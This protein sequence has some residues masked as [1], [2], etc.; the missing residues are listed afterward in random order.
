MT[1]FSERPLAIIA[2]ALIL[3]ALVTLIVRRRGPRITTIET[4]R[5]RDTDD[6]TGA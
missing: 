6:K 4:R 5:E 1:M 3:I 2:V